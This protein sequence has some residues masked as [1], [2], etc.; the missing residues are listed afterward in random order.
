MIVHVAIIH[1]ISMSVLVHVP[2]VALSR[3]AYQCI[4]KAAVTE[5]RGMPVHV[6]WVPR[7]PNYHS[8]DSRDVLE[9]AL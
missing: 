2:Q 8:S 1:T 5:G 6:L 9:S 4:G 7:S 3:D